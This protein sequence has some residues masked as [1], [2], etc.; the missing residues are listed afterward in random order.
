TYA[1][2]RPRC[3]PGPATAVYAALVPFAAVTMFLYGYT[4][5]GIF[6]TSAFLKG[7]VF[8]LVTSVSAALAGA[9]VYRE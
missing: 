4:A 5:M 1:A 8:F 7:T 6:T 3:G 9:S 2:I